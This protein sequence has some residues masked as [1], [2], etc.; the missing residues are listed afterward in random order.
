MVPEL[1]LELEDAVGRGAV[2]EDH[3]RRLALLGRDLGPVRV[4]HGDRDA[5]AHLVRGAPE[6]VAVL[7]VQLDAELLRATGLLRLAVEDLTVERRA[8]AT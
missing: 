1:G 2:L 4:G 8:G 3:V 5:L 7:A 6:P